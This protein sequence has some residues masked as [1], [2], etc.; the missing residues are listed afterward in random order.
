MAPWQVPE[1]QDFSSHRSVGSVG[2]FALTQ[3][4]TWVLPTLGWGKQNVWLAASGRQTLF[5]GVARTHFCPGALRRAQAQNSP[6]GEHPC[7]GRAGPVCRF[8]GWSGG[9][10]PVGGFRWRW[11]ACG[12]AAE[13]KG[14][15]GD[16]APLSCSIKCRERT[17]PKSPISG[18][19][20]VFDFSTRIKDRRR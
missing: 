13:D 10:V 3:P 14:N 8:R 18:P 4:G 11:A 6:A 7:D 19:L 16:P 20:G 9:R 12:A 15:W 1:R 5:A 17:P 2:A